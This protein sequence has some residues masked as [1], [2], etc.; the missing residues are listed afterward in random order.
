MH[1]INKQWI[2]VSTQYINTCIN[3]QNTLQVQQTNLCLAYGIIIKAK[4]KCAYKTFLFEHI[5]CIMY[6][7]NKMFKYI[8]SECAIL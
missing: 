1:S 4:Y 3:I 6:V 2:A 7:L 5:T 8:C